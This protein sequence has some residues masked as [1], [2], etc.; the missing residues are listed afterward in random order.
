MTYLCLIHGAHGLIYY[1]YYDLLRDPKVGFD[2][3]WADMLLVGQEVKALEP[4]LVSIAQPPRIQVKSPDFL[5]H[6][7]RADDAGR[8]YVLLANPNPKS[9]AVTRLQV[10]TKAALQLLRHGR[11]QPVNREI[12]GEEFT[13]TVP[14]LDALTVIIQP[15]S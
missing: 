8:I 4:A 12:A 14:P 5:D 13:V 11:V 7:V 15:S 9:E 10:P 1:S 3:R 6:A 2:Q